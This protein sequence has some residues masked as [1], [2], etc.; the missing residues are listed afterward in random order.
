MMKKIILNS[1]RKRWDYLLIILFVLASGSIFWTYLIKPSGA[2]LILALLGSINANYSYSNINPNKSYRYIGWVLFLCILNFLIVQSSY[3]DNSMFGY[4]VS[5]YAAYIVVSRYN[6]HYFVTILTD[7]IFYITLFGIPIYLLATYEFLPVYD[8]FGAGVNY[9]LFLCYTIGW[10]SFFYRYSGIWHEPGACQ[11][12]LNT[13][14]WLNYDK[15]RRWALTKS[16]KRRLLVIVIGL[17]LTQSTG[18]YLVFMIF[19]L[20]VII[21]SKLPLRKK[22]IVGTSII[23]VGIAIIGLM[24]MNPVVQAKLF[25]TDGESISKADRLGDIEA[26]WKMIQERPILG[27][28]IGTNDFWTQSHRYGNYTCSAGLLTYIASLGI[29]WLIITSYYCYKSVRRLNYGMA[30]WFLLASIVMMQMNEKFIEYPITSIFIFRFYSYN[31]NR[32]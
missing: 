15:I 20:A 3:K 17:L 10:P 7:V 31:F 24:F 16:D 29:P 9:K 25:E 32:R 4:I 18:G 14:L 23:L 8:I 12:I 27:Y 19:V 5:L 13:V 21:N 28:G 2:F 30:T 22:N 26:L 1:N 11:I 6:F